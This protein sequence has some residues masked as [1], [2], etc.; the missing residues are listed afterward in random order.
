M[1]HA[2]FVALYFTEGEL[3]RSEVCGN[4]DCRA[5]RSGDCNLDF[6]PMTFIYELDQYSLD[7]YQMCK[8]ELPT[9]R[10]SKVIV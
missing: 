5:F 4:M 2:N 10:L 6:D 7:I 1:L 8:Y 9:S 3:L